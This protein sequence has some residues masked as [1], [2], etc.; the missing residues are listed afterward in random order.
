MVRAFT[1]ILTNRRKTVLYI[2]STGN[3]TTLDAAEAREKQIK[4][5]RRSK[6][7]DLVRSVNP[8]WL[9][10]QRI[11][12]SGPFDRDPSPSAQDT[13]LAL[14]APATIYYREAIGSGA[15]EIA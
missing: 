7:E 14:K 4:G 9:R 13:S 15:I 2:G 3:L 12:R 5:Y 10:W 11:N 6:K 8:A 1:Y